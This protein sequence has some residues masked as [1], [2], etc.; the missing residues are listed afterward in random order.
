[1]SFLLFVLI[2]SAIGSSYLPLC[3]N[4]LESMKKYVYFYLGNFEDGAG[5][6]A[7][8]AL[9]QLISCSNEGFQYETSL[10]TQ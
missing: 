8:T 10:N 2:N 9:R 1:M 3:L 5:V 6:V 4:T 7:T